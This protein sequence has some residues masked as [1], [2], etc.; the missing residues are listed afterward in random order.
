MRSEP[1]PA[2]FLRLTRARHPPPSLRI[3]SRWPRC[4]GSARGAD[5]T[6]R[7]AL[8]RDARPNPTVF[9]SGRG[10]RARR[11]GRFRRAPGGGRG[12]CRR[13]RTGPSPRPRARFNATHGQTPTYDSLDEGYEHS[14][15]GGFAVR[16]AVGEP[17]VDGPR[18]DRFGRRDARTVRSCAPPGPRRAL[19]VRL[20]ARGV[21]GGG[22]GEEK[23]VRGGGWARRRTVQR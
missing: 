22:R 3:L 12:D 23:N 5:P 14:A 16:S 10:V 19:R 15:P 1:R 9:L 11:A 7:S 8:V 17:I 13:V 4:G 20:P 18:P 6:T 21:V 2:E